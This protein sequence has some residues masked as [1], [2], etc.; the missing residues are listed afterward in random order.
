ME[1]K[2]PMLAG[3]LNMFVPGSVYWFVEKDH[4]RFI[5][6]L[7]GGIV[8]LFA[9]LQLGNAIQRIRNYSLP[10]GVC[11][12]I[13]ILL[14]LVPLFLIGQKT[15]HLHNQ[16]LENTARYNLHRSPLQS[17][18]QESPGE[19]WIPEQAPADKKNESEPKP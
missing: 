18:A 5:K 16:R 17:R 2:N 4:N 12:G 3:L 8:V 19:D 14:V 11:T 6:T 9:V 7:L 15:A 13:L 1:K 10:Q